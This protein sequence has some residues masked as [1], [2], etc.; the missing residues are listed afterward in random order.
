M[1]W[2]CDLT[3]WYI[4]LYTHRT[5]LCLIVKS[6]QKQKYSPRHTFQAYLPSSRCLVTEIFRFLL[7]W[8]GYRG[9][10]Y[11]V[12]WFLGYF[13]PR[14]PSLFWLSPRPRSQTF[15]LQM[16]RSWNRKFWFWNLILIFRETGSDS[17]V[18]NYCGPRIRISIFVIIL[19]Q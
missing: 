19:H 2:C 7:I 6:N 9:I 13:F 16:D 3:K 12:K 10:R 8:R 1:T 17:N 14:V 18:V 5:E 15:L 11:T 4:N